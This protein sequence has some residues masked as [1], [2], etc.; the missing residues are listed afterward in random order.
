MTDLITSA[1][2]AEILGKS[3]RTVQR[4]VVSGD[5][6]PALTLPSGYLFDRADIDA[7]AQTAD[8]AGGAAPADPEVLGTGYSGSAVGL[9][10]A[11]GGRQRQDGEQRSP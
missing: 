3:Q 5:L 1:E 8:P 11:S 2:A 9:V 7:L 6:E 10:T 4:L